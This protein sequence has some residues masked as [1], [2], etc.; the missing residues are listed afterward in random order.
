MRAGQGASRH[1]KRFKAPFLSA[2]IFCASIFRATIGRSALISAALLSVG[3]LQVKPALAQFRPL[4]WS[5]VSAPAAN[6]PEGRRQ[7]LQHSG[8]ASVD[9]SMVLEPI[10]PLVTIRR[11]W[12]APDL[13]PGVPS[14]FIANWGDVFI[15]GSAATA[16]SQRDNVDGSWVAGFGIGDATKNLALEVNAGCGSIK[17]F[18]A[19]GGFGFRV[20]RVLIKQPTGLLALAGGWQNA[21]QWGNEGKQD[22]IYSATLSYAF[23]LRPI[24][25]DFSQTMQINAGVGNSSF[26]PYSATNSEDKIGGFASIGVELSRSVGVSAGWSGRGANAQISYTPFAD[27]PLTINL[28]GADL[29]GQTP[30]GTVAVFSM[31]WG[32][33]FLTPNFP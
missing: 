29:L 11:P 5:T 32:T 10:Q 14:A 25:R 19:N 23:P 26:A 33:N 31:S 6:N 16:G 2:S 12:P 4:Q 18:C 22:N 24:N 20:G 8:A 27:T 17:Q 1:L 15:G 7:L 21:L 13:N 9:P 3:V 28:L 30:S